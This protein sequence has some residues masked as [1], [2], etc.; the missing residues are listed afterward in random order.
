MFYTRF[1]FNTYE[2]Q[3]PWSI[4]KYHVPVKYRTRGWTPQPITDEV[5]AHFSFSTDKERKDWESTLP[6][7]LTKYIVN[8]D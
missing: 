3:D 5:W 6:E 1:K 2:V 4:L 7:Q 8:E